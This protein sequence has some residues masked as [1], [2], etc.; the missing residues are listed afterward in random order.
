M[1]QNSHDLLKF[2]FSSLPA[3]LA[4]LGISEANFLSDHRLRL[5]FFSNAFEQE[6]AKISTVQVETLV[7]AHA[8]Q[9]NK[10]PLP[11]VKNIIAIASGKGGVGK[12]TTSAN[13]AAAFSQLGARVG[14]LDADIYGP[15][16][17]HLFGIADD[18]RPGVEEGKY[19]V[20]IEREGIHTL[21]MGNLM[22][23][24]TP[25]V[26]RGPKASG[27]L[28]QML[29]QTLWPDLD[30]LLIDLPPGTG[31]IQLTMAQQ[32]PTVGAVVVTTPQ[33]LALLDGKKAI[34]MF[35]KVGIGVL[36]IVENMSVHI[37]SKCGHEESIFGVQGGQRLAD[38]YSMQLLGQLPL[39]MAIRQQGDSGRPITL[40]EPEGNIAQRYRMIAEKVSIAIAMR[41]LAPQPS[42]RVTT[43]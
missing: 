21:S 4:E 40:L 34:E 41:D 36:G 10:P 14:V 37:C 33:D 27:A 26:W 6:L 19:F 23:E 7:R 2:P 13:L 20:P 5:G 38:D 9:K 43:Q 22:N 42:I 16:I 25:A 17:P 28:M 3:T 31:D 30:Y 12:S 24:K 29:N 18:Q 1:S 32:I 8:A 35:E 15:S 39:H 11:R